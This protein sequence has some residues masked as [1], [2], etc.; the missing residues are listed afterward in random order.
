MGL[1]LCL[2]LGMARGLLATVCPWVLSDTGI[3]EDSASLTMNPKSGIWKVY[4]DARLVT[5]EAHLTQ[6][7]STWGG[8][9]PLRTLG[10]SGDIFTC[11]EWG[12]GRRYWH[13]VSADQG[14]R[15][16]PIMCWLTLAA[17]NDLE[18]LCVEAEI[19]WFLII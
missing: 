7:F 8:L 5:C 2:P 10:K 12:Q 6:L 19:P 16:C 14:C 3:S 13:L 15:E 11:Q 1:V 18:L 4:W 17:E 9:C